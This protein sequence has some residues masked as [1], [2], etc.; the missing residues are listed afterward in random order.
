MIAIQPV[1]WRV[2]RIYRK[3]SSLYCCVLDRVYRAVAWQRVDHNHYNTVA[4]LPQFLTYV[5]YTRQNCDRKIIDLKI[6]MY[7]R[8]FNHLVYKMFLVHRVSVCIWMNVH[9]CYESKRNL[10][11]KETVNCR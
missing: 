9:L 6:S 3:H 11:H 1:Y 4:V 5:V 2:G 10:K 7:L 8:V